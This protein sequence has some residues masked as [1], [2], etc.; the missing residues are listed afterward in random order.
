M[1]I[2]R[3]PQIGDIVKIKNNAFPFYP[4]KIY[5]GI[6]VIVVC[7]DT[8][9]NFIGVKPLGK[10]KG[11]WIKEIDIAYFINKKVVDKP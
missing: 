10:D 9:W 3:K 7:F 2:E 4:Y 11:F 6:E 1:S 8:E 5:N